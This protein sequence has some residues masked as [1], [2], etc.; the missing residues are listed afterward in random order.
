VTPNQV[1]AVTDRLGGD[2]LSPFERFRSIAS[3]RFGVRYG[4]VAVLP[5]RLWR[6]APR[7]RLIAAGKHSTDGGAGRLAGTPDA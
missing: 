6:Q 4:G 2:T 1:V 5:R 3:A 7:L